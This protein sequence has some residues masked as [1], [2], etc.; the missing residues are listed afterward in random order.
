MVQFHIIRCIKLQEWAEIEFKDD[1]KHAELINACNKEF[2][3]TK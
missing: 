2:N 3:K 1:K